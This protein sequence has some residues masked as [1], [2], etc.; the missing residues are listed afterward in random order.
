MYNDERFKYTYL[1]IEI[2]AELVEL[3]DSGKKILMI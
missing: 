2:V 3:L 1:V